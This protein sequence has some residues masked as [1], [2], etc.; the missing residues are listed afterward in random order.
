MKFP[1]FR[2]QSAPCPAFPERNFS[3]RPVIPIHI[4]SLD[5]KTRFQHYALLDTGADYNLF[6]ADLLDVLGVGDV[7]SGK[8]QDMFGI[9]GKGVQT[10]FHNV[11]IGVGKWRYKAYSGF[12]DFGMVTSPDH[13][14]Y[15]IL[16]QVGCFE[17][18]EVVFDYKKLEVE[19]KPKDDIKNDN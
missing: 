2:F 5:L 11:I 13:M 9:E 10:Y 12:T 7:K 8:R 16:G 6:H 3:Y 15:G 18:F 1:Y 14:P 4:Y 19:I 17:H